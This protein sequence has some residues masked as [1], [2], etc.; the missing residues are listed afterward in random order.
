MTWEMTVE[1]VG[2]IVAM[3]AIVTP[4]VKL[5]MNISRLNTTI[6]ILSK[7]TQEKH[8]NLDKRVS[9]HGD[10]IDALEKVTVNHEVRI[11]N[12]EKEK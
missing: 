6:E 4:I 7:D 2:F 1:L 8:S 9:K 3:I 11:T 5:N 12:I 10:Q